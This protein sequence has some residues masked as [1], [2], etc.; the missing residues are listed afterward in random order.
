MQRGGAHPQNLREYQDQY[1][2]GM[3]QQK[4][5]EFDPLF[6]LG[7]Q[8]YFK[9]DLQK[10][11]ESINHFIAMRTHI[12]EIAK[13]DVGTQKPSHEITKQIL[14]K[15]VYR[16]IFLQDQENYENVLCATESEILRCRA[17]LKELRAM[18]DDA[19][20]SKVRTV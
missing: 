6:F 15:F 17:E 20:L 10:M 2:E 5:A 1:A 13:A 7:F 9:K 14:N 11:N 12:I 18:H 4:V 8:K 3:L 19:V 16:S